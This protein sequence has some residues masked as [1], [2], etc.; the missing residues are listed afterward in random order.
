MTRALGRVLRRRASLSSGNGAS[1]HQSDP[2]QRKRSDRPKKRGL[3]QSASTVK[4]FCG[5]FCKTVTC[6]SKYS[7]NPLNHL[8]PPISDSSPLT[9]YSWW[10]S[11]PKKKRPTASTLIGPPAYTPPKARLPRASHPRSSPANAAESQKP[12][13]YNPNRLNKTLGSFLHFA[14]PPGPLCP[15]LPPKHC[16]RFGS[17]NDPML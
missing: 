7:L 12:I 5:E 3:S 14:L 8:Q 17:R 1:C 13:S 6:F 2:K 16:L 11:I 4:P 10:M 15:E 9:C